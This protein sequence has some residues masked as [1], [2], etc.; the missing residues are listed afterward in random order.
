MKL[1]KF[2]LPITIMVKLGPVKPL[3]HLTKS[4]FYK[5]DPLHDKSQNKLN[6]FQ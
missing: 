4:V 1:N 3:L 5:G 2:S 6:Y